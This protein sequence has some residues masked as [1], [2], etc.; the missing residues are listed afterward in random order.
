MQLVHSLGMGDGGFRLE[1][2]APVRHPDG[3]GT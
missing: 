3:L 1:S 2:V